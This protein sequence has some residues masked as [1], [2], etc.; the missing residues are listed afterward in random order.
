LPHGAVGH[1]RAAP[2][3]RYTFLASIGPKP[4][5]AKAS[6]TVRAVD[7]KPI[8]PALR[9]AARAC[10][11]ADRR[12]PIGA[13]RVHASDRHRLICVEYAGAFFL[14]SEVAVDVCAARR[15]VDAI[16]VL[17]AIDLHARTKA[18]VRPSHADVVLRTVI[19]EVTRK[20]AVHTAPAFA[21]EARHA[22][23]PRIAARRS[24]DAALAL[25]WDFDALTPW[26]G[27]TVVASYAG[28]AA[29]KDA[30]FDRR[31]LEAVAPGLDAHEA[32]RAVVTRVTEPFTRTGTA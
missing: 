23:E 6:R 2:T 13:V 20:P 12:R 5:A 9:G 24:L 27:K 7:A 31:A 30:V 3:A 15:K 19:V 26:E 21:G 32:D 14:L 28:A 17:N 29:A 22:V 18:P 4:D 1:V 25:T 10:R 16:E 11:F 8:L